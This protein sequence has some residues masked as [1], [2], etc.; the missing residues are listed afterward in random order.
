MSAD[1]DCNGSVQDFG[2][3]SLTNQTPD[4]GAVAQW[5][6][7]IAPW[8]YIAISVDSAGGEYD[9]GADLTG[10]TEAHT[11]CGPQVFAVTMFGRSVPGNALILTN[12]N[13]SGNYTWSG[14]YVSRGAEHV[15]SA[16]DVTSVATTTLPTTDIDGDGVIDEIPCGSDPAA[17]NRR[18]E[19][20]D[21]TF[22]G[23]DDDGD[24]LVDELL[25]PGAGIYDCDGDGYKGATEAVVFA[26]A[27]RRDQKPCGVDGWPS[28]FVSGG[29]PSSTDRVT[30]TDLTSFIGP[31][32][33]M[34]TSQ[35]DPGFNI[36]W[37]LVPGASG[38][39]KTINIA[40][41]TALISG[42]TATPPMLGGLRALGGP[43]CPWSQTPPPTP[44]PTP[45]PPASTPTPTP[46]PISTPTP[47]PTPTATP[48]PGTGDSDGDGVIDEVPCGS[49]PNDAS[50]RPERIDG[51]F[52]NTDDDGDQAIDE[53]LPV[54]AASYDCDGDGYLG[55]VEDHVFDPALRRDQDTCGLDGWPSDFVSGGVPLSTNRITI[56]DVTAFIAPARRLNTSS[57]DTG[58]SVRYD[59]QPGRG[60]FAETI[61]ISDLTTLFAGNTGSPPM[62]LGPRAL[63]GPTCPWP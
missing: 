23:L 60:V 14:S 4:P 24:G 38:L 31:V 10:L 46:T 49:N 36:R 12:P 26:L 56:T 42:S 35:S 5:E 28:D 34:N 39:G 29:V 19:R 53:Q 54:G 2:P 9:L 48:P 16:S 63:N 25:P 41:L 15:A 17:S 30:I 43:A 57:G 6:G 55:S 21:S 44:T 45:S 32:R 18:P 22:S 8:W 52:I 50:K 47:T 13:S 40:D 3:F 58:Y 20:T 7:Q 37:D 27:T 59:L 11:I 51:S 62:L 61:N 33:R 1:V